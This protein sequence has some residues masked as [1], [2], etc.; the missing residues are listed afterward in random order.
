MKSFIT[1]ILITLAA[2]SLSACSHTIMKEKM[3]PCPP[4]ASTGNN[5]CE[6]IPINFAS[7]PAK[8]SLV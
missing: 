3:A 1:A 5:P 7:V 8:N 2:F 6:L 4:M